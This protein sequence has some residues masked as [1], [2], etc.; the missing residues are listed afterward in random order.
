MST[1]QKT[2]GDANSF[3]YA[4][5][6]WTGGNA[7]DHK[8]ECNYTMS[9]S[10]WLKEP[11]IIYWVNGGGVAYSGKP[12]QHATTLWHN[13]NS[14][15][16][17]KVLSKLVNQIRGHDFNLGIVAAEGL[18]TIS[19]IKDSA[20]AVLGAFY[21]V[22]HGRID[23]ALRIFA[24]LV[25]G[26]DILRKNYSPSKLSI[27]DI[28]EMWLALK[29]AW[30]P[31]LQD[32]HELGKALDNNFKDVR[33]VTFVARATA[34]SNATNGTDTYPTYWEMSAMREYRVTVRES[35]SVARSLGLQNPASV[36]WEVVPYSFVVDWFIPIGSYLD[37]LGMLSNLSKTV[38][39]TTV[40]RSKCRARST[41]C[42]AGGIWTG[43][44]DSWCC[45]P[46]GLNAFTYHKGWTVHGMEISM[47]RETNVSINVPL[48]GLKSL[49]Q[50]F[51]IAH[52]Q[53]AAALISAAMSRARGH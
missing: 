19:S 23:D 41:P 44:H 50:A 52:I 4:I 37:S 14:N 24:R 10:W 53:N 51:G 12:W 26:A 34:K 16:E 31:M 25:Q 39:R 38:N 28:A 5:K 40:M 49:E 22:R 47:S 20:L 29:Y 45:P 1:G 21:A 30:Q 8:T 32:I 11:Y 48:P 33:K 6:T 9:S 7:P 35:I 27:S 3:E 13:W 46:V 36:I 18:K 42:R 2:R 17:L 15:D 43:P